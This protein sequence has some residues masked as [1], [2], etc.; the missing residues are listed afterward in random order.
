MKKVIFEFV[1]QDAEE[2][3]QQFYTWFIDGG[4]ED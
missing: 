4:L 2:M 1:R 3:T